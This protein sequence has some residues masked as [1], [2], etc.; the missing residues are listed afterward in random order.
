MAKKTMLNVSEVSPIDIDSLLTQ[1]DKISLDSPTTPGR[2]ITFELRRYKGEA[3]INQTSVYAGNKRN[4][5]FLTKHSMAPLI[6]SI[7]QNNQVTPAIARTTGNE[8]SVIYGSCRRLATYYASKTFVVL[9]SDDITDDEAKA[10]TQAENISSHISL[11]ERGY[12]WLKHQQEDELTLRQIATDIEGGKV[13]HTLIGVGINGAKIDVALL[14]LYPSINVIGK[15]TIL[16]LNRALHS[17]STT[18]ATQIVD[19]ITTEHQQTI[20][21]LRVAYKHDQEINCT[22]LTKL[23]VDYCNEPKPQKI[24]KDNPP[25]WT[26]QVK[27]KTNVKG[28]VTGVTFNKPLNAEAAQQLQSMINALY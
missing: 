7:K 20:E 9:V 13:S 11:I 17:A 26:S 22:E 6:D 12:G 28:L 18:T 1:G 3:I 21:A 25:G 27:V 8:V 14:M 19:F 16:K 10:I 15:P 24:V 23:I 2:T 4:Q 5:Q